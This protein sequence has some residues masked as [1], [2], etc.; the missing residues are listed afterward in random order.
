MSVLS[1]CCLLLD[2]KSSASCSLLLAFFSFFSLFWMDTGGVG[3]GES[4]RE[5][6][7]QTSVSKRQ[8][9]S[10]LVCSSELSC[11]W[12]VCL[13]SLSL[14]SSTFSSF[15]SIWFCLSWQRALCTATFRSPWRSPEK[16]ESPRDVP[17]PG[18]APPILHHLDVGEQRL[19]GRQTFSQEERRQGGVGVA[20]RQRQL[21]IGGLVK[22][23][24]QQAFICRINSKTEMT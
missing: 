7:A 19:H 11:L 15:L 2:S 12:R 14:S 23:E 21:L 13:A 18:R 22:G 4:S 1:T 9:D 17:K 20:Q 3:G 6:P 8:P 24:G 5:E 16:P 10:P